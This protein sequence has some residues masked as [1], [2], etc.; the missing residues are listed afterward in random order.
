M[1]ARVSVELPDHVH[2]TRMRHI[3]DADLASALGRDPRLLRAE[4][5]GGGYRPVWDPKP[6]AALL[7]RAAVLADADALSDRVVD[8]VSGDVGRSS[9]YGLHYL[10]WLTPLLH[11]YELTGDDRHAATFGRIFDDWYDS[12]DHV[13]GDWP[14][15]DV[16]WY[17]LGVWARAGLLVPAMVT[18]AD[19]PGVPGATY[20]RMLKT[21]VGGA[22]WAAEEHVAFRPGNWQLVCA[23]ELLHVAAF[24]PTAPEAGI[25]ARTGRART[26]EHLDRDCYADGG[27]LERS[28]GYHDMCLNALQRAA[29][30]AERSLGWSLA[31]HPRFA[32]MHRW[33]LEMA[34]PGGWVPPWQDTTLVHPAATLLRGNYFRPDPQVAAAVRRWLPAERITAELE[35][36]PAL[37]DR[38]DPVAAFAAMPGDEGCPA[39]LRLL[40]T[41]GYAVFRSGEAFLA[42]NVGDYVEHELESHSHL[43]VTDFVIAYGGEP[44]AVEA[45]GPATYDD[46]EYQTWYRAPAAHTMVTVDGATMD[47]DRGCVVDRCVDAGDVCVLAAHHTGYRRRVDRRITFVARQPAYW[48]VHDEVAGGVPAT[49][50]I[51]A[52]TPWQRVDG[53]WRGGSLGVFPADDLPA[54]VDSGPGLLPDGTGATYSRLHVLRLHAPTGRFDV[55]V[56]PTPGSW[57]FATDGDGW[58]VATDAVVDTLGVD[59]WVRRTAAGEPVATVEVPA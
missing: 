38:G 13:V 59:R 30:V 12:R 2:P 49:W 39:G 31:E 1:T 36:L 41:S 55:L 23:A 15:L 56:V 24:L 43:A 11:A 58:R 8:F 3:T 22:R 6:E 46:P 10:R 5:A 53:G 29:A 34:T 14:G 35:V 40:D 42:V 52:P 51:L 7:D 26:V 48:L 47:T 19:A 33:L 16:V 37:P 45:G 20:A 57:R 21:V 17:S 54:T 4:L 9:L 50:S 25:W 44:L 27:H 32:A 28:P 18:F